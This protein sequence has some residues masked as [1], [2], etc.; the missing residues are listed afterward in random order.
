M[1]TVWNRQELRGTY[2][3]P[4]EKY[5]LIRSAR[6][7]T[8]NTTHACLKVGDILIVR[9]VNIAKLKDPDSKHLKHQSFLKVLK[10]RNKDWPPH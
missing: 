5:F 1:H 9:S 7:C 6:Y 4:F 3:L 10:K 8:D 2:E